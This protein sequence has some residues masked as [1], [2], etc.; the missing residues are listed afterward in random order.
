MS[1]S[2]LDRYVEEVGHF[3][4]AELGALADGPV[5]AVLARAG[6]GADTLAPDPVRGRALDFPARLQCLDLDTYL[7]G[8]ILTKVD[9]MSM[10]HSI[11]ARVPLLDHTLVEFVAGLPAELTLRRGQGKYL[12]KR[13]LTGMV[14]DAI[15]ARPKRGFGVPLGYWFR[16]GLE[17][18]LA[19]HLLGANAR[20]RE[21]V[22]RG[23]VQRLFTLFRRTGR[24]AYLE[25][26]WTILVLEL[27]RREL[28]APAGA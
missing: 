21:Y 25:K 22:R 9:R 24:T 27:W 13:A 1:L 15:L 11:E 19:D 26:L 8:D 23:S 7:P 18:F 12:F 5:A 10:A 2:R 20:S 14:P 17:D 28:A 4:F 3:S 16:D 6:V